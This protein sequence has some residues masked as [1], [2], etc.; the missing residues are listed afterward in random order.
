MNLFAIK[1]PPNKPSVIC[2]LPSK[3]LKDHMLNVD[4]VKLVASV[5]L[6]GHSLKV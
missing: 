5:T 3:V 6:N 1:A 2:I 4:T